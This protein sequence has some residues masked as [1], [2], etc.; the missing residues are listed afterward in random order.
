MSLDE[1]QGISSYKMC[2]GHL[3]YYFNKHNKEIGIYDTITGSIKPVSRKWNKDMLKYY[4]KKEV[5]D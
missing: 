1:L 5:Y 2:R 3:E 4:T